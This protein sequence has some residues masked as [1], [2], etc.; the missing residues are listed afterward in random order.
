MQRAGSLWL[1]PT[2][3][4]DD[5]YWLYGAVSAGHRGVLVSND[6]MRDH[7]FELLRPR[8]FDR[9]RTH[10]RFTYDW[11]DFEGGRGVRWF[12]KPPDVFTTCVQ[13]LPETGAWLVPQGGS[14]WM[15]AK[16]V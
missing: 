9:W 7:I 16:P 1:T 8:Y 4:N 14:K 5:W 10:H 15:C 12:L 3:S 13:Q 2:G 6:L 11:E